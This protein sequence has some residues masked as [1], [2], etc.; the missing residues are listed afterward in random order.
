MSRHSST[1]PGSSN[2]LSVAGSRFAFVVYRVYLP[3]VGVDKTGGVGVPAVTL[4][5]FSGSSRTLRPCPFAD[6]EASLGNLILL[7]EAAG[8]TDAARFLGQI[9]ILANQSPL[10]PAARTNRVRLLSPSAQRSPAQIFFRIRKQRTFK[11]PTFVFSGTKF[12]SSEARLPSFPKLI[13]LWAV[14]SLNRPS[15]ARSSYAI[16]RCA[17]MSGYFLP[18]WWHVKQ[19]P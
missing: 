19:M 18:R 7:L 13:L 2:L 10:G 16:G 17:I 15:M 14:P 1:N 5:D 4:I 12:W 8:M 6:A 11:P 3:D 9:L